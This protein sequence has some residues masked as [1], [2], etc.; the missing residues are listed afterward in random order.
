[1]LLESVCVIACTHYKESV[2]SYR[3]FPLEESLILILFLSEKHNNYMTYPHKNNNNKHALCFSVSLERKLL[4]SY[5]IGR[6]ICVI[7]RK[8]SYCVIGK[9]I[10]SCFVTGR[11][12]FEDIFGPLV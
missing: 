12:L 2:H 11:Q 9:K 6:Q 7:R 3:N 8:L 1:V 10:V 5:V 4:S